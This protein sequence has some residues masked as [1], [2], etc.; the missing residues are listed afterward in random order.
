MR[1][2]R[3]DME[4]M[5]MV[6]AGVAAMVED[7]D[8]AVATVIDHGARGDGVCCYTDTPALLPST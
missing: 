5:V 1:W 4:V 8:M 6:V 3:T 7:T 2:L